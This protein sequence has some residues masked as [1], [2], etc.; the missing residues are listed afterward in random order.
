MKKRATPGKA[1]KMPKQPQ[2]P[3]KPLKLRK[4]ASK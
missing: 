1:P 3:P 4:G 2:K